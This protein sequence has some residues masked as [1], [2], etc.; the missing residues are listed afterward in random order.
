[1]ALINLAH[2]V[3]VNYIIMNQQKNGI[4]L[5]YRVCTA[6]VLRMALLGL[7]RDTQFD[8]SLSGHRIY[9]IKIKPTINTIP[10]CNKQWFWHSPLSRFMYIFFQIWKKHDLF[11]RVLAVLAHQMALLALWWD[12]RLKSVNLGYTTFKLTQQHLTA[13][14]SDHHVALSL[15]LIT[16]CSWN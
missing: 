13:T 5:S 7:W 6:P 11:C 12:T 10:H 1:M 3:I 8:N 16:F 9:C 2:Q 14:T 4:T 15:H